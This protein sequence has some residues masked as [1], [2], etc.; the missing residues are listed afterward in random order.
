MDRNVKWNLIILSKRVG[1]PWPGNAAGME[2]SGT[3]DAKG[4]AG[5][6]AGIK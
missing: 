5:Y 4:W 6:D 1:E 2:A 3:V